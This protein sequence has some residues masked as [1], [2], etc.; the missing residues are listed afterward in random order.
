VKITLVSFSGNWI[1]KWKSKTEWLKT[2]R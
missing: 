2:W 1:K